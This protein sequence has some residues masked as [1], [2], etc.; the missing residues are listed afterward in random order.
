VS[1]QVPGGSL[2]AFNDS[3]EYLGKLEDPNQEFPSSHYLPL[4]MA[5]FQIQITGETPIQLLI[6]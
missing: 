3:L 4:T 5:V 2:F 6:K 1:I